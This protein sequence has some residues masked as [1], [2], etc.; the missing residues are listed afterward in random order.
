MWAENQT[1]CADCWYQVPDPDPD[2]GIE[3]PD[4]DSDPDPGI[5]EPEPEPDSDPDPDPDSDPDPGIDPDPDPGIDPDPDP[6]IE[7]DPEPGIEDPDPGIPPILPDSMQ[8]HAGPAAGV[9]AGGASVGTKAKKALIQIFLKEWKQLPSWT[10]PPD[11][12]T[13][14]LLTFML[15]V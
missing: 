1:K 10:D 14:P 7:P 5:V 2:P 12:V 15:K 4:P 9:G 3:D 13:F 11:K 6:G 8:E